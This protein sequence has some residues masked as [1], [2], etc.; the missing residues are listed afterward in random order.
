MLIK[1]GEIISKSVA[2]YRDNAKLL[3]SYVGLLLIPTSVLQIATVLFSQYA[4]RSNL[5]MTLLLI[6]VFSIAISIVNVWITI[7]MVRAIAARYMGTSVKDVKTELS[8][9]TPVLLTAILAS[10]LV[11]LVVIGGMILLIIPGIIFSVWFA[12]VF[13]AV[14]LDN[15]KTTEAMKASK[16]L[17]SGRW[18]SVFWLLLA[19]GIVFAVVMIILQWTAGLLVF[20]PDMFGTVGMMAYLVIVTAAGLIAAPLST[21]APTILYLEL[22]KT[23]TATPKPAMEV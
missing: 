20:L 15:K 12:F 18:W 17:V 3:L 2:L 21:T 22:K 7:A 1:A 19:P 4:T 16:A 9:S 13:Y 6:V 23:P 10:I 11:G 8:G 14:V 5:G